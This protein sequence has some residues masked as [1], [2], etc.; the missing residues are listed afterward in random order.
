MSQ[1]KILIIDDETVTTHIIS[2]KIEKRG[3]L[4]EAINDP[5]IILN[6][7]QRLRDY[8]VVL[9]DI[10]MPQISGI[11]ML[12]EIRKHYSQNILPVIMMTAQSSVED[13]VNAL[14]LGA[15]DYV[16]K[17][18]NLDIL[19]S[20]IQTQHKVIAL[21]KEQEFRKQI[22]AIN[23]MVATYHHEI[24]NPLAIATGSL[25]KL[26]SNLESNQPDKQSIERLEHALE[27]IATIV[28]KIE[29][30]NEESSIKIEEYIK[31]SSIVK[32]D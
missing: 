19:V 1:K 30:I 27:R 12:L 32:L 3:F 25:H 31:G 5:Q 14:D 17:P 20:R 15:N 7:I 10:V 13:I 4:V 9:L 2:Q 29:E 22:E 23:A 28:S 26:S 16:T 21:N 18:V 6:D 11:D 8:S 24:N